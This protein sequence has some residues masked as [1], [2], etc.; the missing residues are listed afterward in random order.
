MSDFSS[1]AESDQKQ[2][3]S[4][5]TFQTFSIK[6]FLTSVCNYYSEKESLMI[7]KVNSNTGYF[8]SNNVL[9]NTSVGCFFVYLSF[10]YKYTLKEQI[11]KRLCGLAVKISNCWPMELY[12]T[13][14]QNKR[15]GCF[16]V[17]SSLINIV[18]LCYTTKNV[19]LKQFGSKWNTNTK[20][21]CSV[22]Y[23]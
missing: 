14:V 13:F 20:N 7:R 16:L 17:S 15:G 3:V 5:I 6:A 1:S 18:W 8:T 21:M 23:S 2:K 11:P 19:Y 4:F 10:T 9:I 22:L 12:K